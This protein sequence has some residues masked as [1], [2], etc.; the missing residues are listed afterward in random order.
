MTP[1]KIT[2]KH[3]VL[4]LFVL[5][6]K[7]ITNCFPS[8]SSCCNVILHAFF[9]FQNLIEFDNFNKV[10]FKSFFGLFYTRTKDYFKLKFIQTIIET[11]VYDNR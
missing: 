10:G 8:S 9:L 7:I 5:N 6:N 4:G 11:Y 3:V 2:T 1:F